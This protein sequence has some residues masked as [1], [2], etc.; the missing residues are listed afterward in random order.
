MENPDKRPLPQGW[1]TQYDSRYYVNTSASPPVTVWEHPLGAPPPAPPPSHYAPP[2]GP[3]PP[4]HN[5]YPGQTHPI[6]TTA[7]LKGNMGDTQVQAEEAQAAIPGNSPATAHPHNPNTADTT[8][9][10]PPEAGA[11]TSNLP[12]S[13]IGSKPRRLNKEGKARRLFGGL[14]GKKPSSGYGGGGGY[15]QQQQPVYAQA[16]AK[17]G[18]MG[19]GGMLAAGGAGLIG[20][21][22]IAN[23][24]DDSQEDAYREGYEDAQDGG[25]FDDD[26]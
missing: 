20:G 4:N 5:T 22:L 18:G 25:G 9:H 23:A 24:L 2:P 17:S 10:P 16:P 14:F 6:V 12:L 7:I 11:D 1:I 26:F 15:G 3:P 19:M 8:P 13:R 21:A